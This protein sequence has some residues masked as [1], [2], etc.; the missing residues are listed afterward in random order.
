MQAIQ[1]FIERFAKPTFAAQLD[2]LTK[3]TDGSEL[4]LKT[5][6]QELLNRPQTLERLVKKANTGR[7]ADG[8][9]DLESSVRFLGI[10]NVRVVLIAEKLA[11]V[12][13]SK[14]LERN[15]QT[16]ELLTPPGTLLQYAV[17]SLQTFG[18]DSPQKDIAFT[19]GLIFDLLTLINAQTQ[20]AGK[21]KKIDTFIAETFIEGLQIAE[22]ALTLG[23]IRNRLVL[24]RHLVSITMINQA[25]Y[26]AGA[27]MIEDYLD[28]LTKL[29]QNGIPLSSQNLAS[30]Q[31][32]KGSHS[33]FATLIA[34][35]LPIFDGI[36]PALLNCE[37]PYL[38]GDREEINFFDVAAISFLANHLFRHQ[39]QFKSGVPIQARELRPELKKFDLSFD[40]GAI[41]T[42]KEK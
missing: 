22:A 14:L 6:I 1:E 26:V 7:E 10:Q 16:Q 5:I 20:D 40:I 11:D 29:R 42:K 31:Q 35:P 28:H 21:K 19:S 25:S 3:E 32:F 27:V 24:G 12:F 30:I 8:L 17:K 36:T 34:W 9:L 39:D 23:K 2:P 18:E 41:F 13:D 33:A 37:A 38:L 15:T 4:L